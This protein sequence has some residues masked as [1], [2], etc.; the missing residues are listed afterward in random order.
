MTAVATPTRPPGAATVSGLLARSFF[1]VALIPFVPLALLTFTTYRQEVG[2]VEAD[3]LAAN[4]QVATLAANHLDGLLREVRRTG[5]LFRPASVT[6]LPPPIPGVHWETV[7]RDG[8]IL[9]SQLPTPRGRVG[10]SYLR[11]L[12]HLPPGGALS[13]VTRFIEGWPPTVLAARAMGDGATCLVAVLDPEELHRELAA[14]SA[15]PPARHVYAVA[16]DGALLFYS[17]LALSR[18][19]ADLRANPPIRMFLEGRTG[20]LRYRSQVS[21]RQRLGVVRRLQE[22]PWGVVASADAGVRL[23]AL[24]TRYAALGLSIVFAVGAAL[25]ILAWTSRRLTGPLLAVRN[26]MREQALDT[27]GPL[28]LPAGGTGLVELDQLVGAFNDLQ[29]RV[30][31]AEEELLQAEK[32]ALLGQLAS[33][34]AHELGTPL[35]IIT[36]H[37]QVLLRRLGARDPARETLE[38]ILRQAERIS[39]M[40][41][42]LL[43]FSRPVQ[44]RRVPVQLDRVLRGAVELTRGLTQGLDV[45]LDLDPNT[46]PVLGDSRL[47]E[48]AF[49]NLIVNACQAMPRGGRL[50]LGVGESHS[51]APRP[52]RVCAWVADSGTGIAP[53]ILPRI[54]EPFFTTKAQGQGTGLGLPIVERIVRQHGGEI[55]VA[56]RPGAGAVFTVTLPALR[57]EPGGGDGVEEAVPAARLHPEREAQS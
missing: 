52:P 11:F 6:E 33:G 48:H 13:Q 34:I 23:L 41:R 49:S 29:T 22:A 39:G 54:F 12:A 38:N 10:D 40:V 47:L 36:G 19:G 25:A 55:H 27:P 8:T 2:R 3:I 44:P 26:V 4:R 7:A 43:D 28:Q 45:R 20:E 30:A 17:D 31:A 37:A 18:R 15:P 14:L 42:R 46:P 51:D 9:A 16:A 5:E 32:V 53:D 57:G 21:S 56:S 50:S 35:N 24:R 1:L